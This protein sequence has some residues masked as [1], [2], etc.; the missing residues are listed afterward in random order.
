MVKL[1][2]ETN[3]QPI[4]RRLNWLVPPV[5]VVFALLGIRL[6]WLQILQG[7]QYTRLAEQNRIR[8]IPINAARGPIL[9]R[10][11]RLLVDNRPSLNIVLYRELMRDQAATEEFVSGRLGISREQLAAQ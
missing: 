5:I 8:S 11:R 1:Q 4:Q 2:L 3:R 9:D 6:W 10:N 7:A